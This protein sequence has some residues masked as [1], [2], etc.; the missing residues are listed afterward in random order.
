MKTL[1]LEISD[2]QI[3]A[4]QPEQSSQQRNNLG[5]PLYAKD[6]GYPTDTANPDRSSCSKFTC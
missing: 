2:K 5:N 4:L 1:K 3:N 6:I